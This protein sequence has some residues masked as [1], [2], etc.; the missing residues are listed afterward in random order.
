MLPDGQ[1]D[2]VLIVNTYHHIG[3]RKAYFRNLLL[4]LAP[5]GRVA[6]VEPNEEL[7]GMLSFFVKEGH[8][9]RAAD[10]ERE[11]R[12]AGYRRIKKS[13]GLPFQIFEIYGR[14]D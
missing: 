12:A 6:V 4:D 2:L 1:I 14:S 10:V 9:S 11:M 7:T 13:D 5:S 3:D 8:A